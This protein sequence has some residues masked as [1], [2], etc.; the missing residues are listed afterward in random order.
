[1]FAGQTQRPIGTLKMQVLGPP[2][3]TFGLDVD[4]AAGSRMDVVAL[5]VGAIA[6][7]VVRRELPALAIESRNSAAR[8]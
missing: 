1:M 5:D 4:D 8:C 2:V 7:R 6:E 3:R